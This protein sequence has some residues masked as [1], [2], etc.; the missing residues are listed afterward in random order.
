LSTPAGLPPEVLSDAKVT[1]VL[2]EPGSALQL[3]GERLVVR[4]AGNVAQ[5]VP[6][7]RVDQVLVQT[8]AASLSSAAVRACALQGVPV[9]LLEPT[10]VPY[11]V[12]SSPHLVG[13]VATRRAQL[14]AYDDERGGQLAIAMAAGKLANQAALLKYIGKYRR[15]GDTATY[16]VLM[17]TAR[18]IEVLRDQLLARPAGLADTVR[19]SLLATEGQAGGLYWG[20]IGC[21]VPAAFAFPGREHRGATDPINAALNYGYGILQSQVWAALVFAGLDP[22]AGYIHVDRPGRPALVLDLMEEFRPVVVDRVVVAM[23]NTGQRIVLEQGLLD[24]E[25]RRLVARRVLERLEARERHG[26]R[27]FALRSILRLQARAVVAHVRGERPY[28]PFASRW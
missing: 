4:V 24:H 21:V 28:R 23:A 16:E 22:F 6:V 25:S 20:A 3:T 26:R 10:G 5:E 7:V 13:T 9:T 1:L 18:R 17:D 2:S 8:R 11:A 12:V 15:H 19:P 27:H 14:R